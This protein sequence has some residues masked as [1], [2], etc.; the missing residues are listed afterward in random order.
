MVQVHT[1]QPF[2]SYLLSLMACLN[3]DYGFKKYPLYILANQFFKV[4]TVNE[5]LSWQDSLCANIHDVLGE[6]GLVV[7]A[8]EMSWSVGR[9]RQQLILL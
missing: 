9:G 7:W 5:T 3:L 2:R 8:W 1:S 6:M 4:F